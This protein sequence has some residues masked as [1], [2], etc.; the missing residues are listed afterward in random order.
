MKGSTEP[1]P[2]F[3]FRFRLEESQDDR[4]ARWGGPLETPAGH[5]GD[6]RDKVPNCKA[7]CFATERQHLDG[8]S[9][10]VDADCDGLVDDEDPECAHPVGLILAFFPFSGSSFSRYYP[11]MFPNYEPRHGAWGLISI[12]FLAEHGDLQA[13]EL[14][15]PRPEGLSEPVRH[16]RRSVVRGCLG[17]D[18]RARPVITEICQP[19]HLR[20]PMNPPATQAYRPANGNCRPERAMQ[21]P[22]E[23]E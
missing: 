10:G 2:R 4:A 5:G 7:A 17:G 1:D 23:E 8:C 15:W 20:N 3:R 6:C 9:D 18:S 19:W 14:H 22:G 11:G 13:S 16:A 12:T 21:L